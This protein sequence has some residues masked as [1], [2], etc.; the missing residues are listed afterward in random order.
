MTVHCGRAEGVEGIERLVVVVV[1]EGTLLGGERRGGGDRGGA[2]GLPMMKSA[3]CGLGDWNG[4]LARCESVQR[5]DFGGE[6]AE[7]GGLH[8]P[9]MRGLFE[10]RVV[11]LEVVVILT[12]LVEP[13]SLD[14]HPRVRASEAS[15]RE[16]TDHGCS[17]EDVGIVKRDGNLAESAVS[18]AA[19]EH[20]V[21]ALLANQAETF[22]RN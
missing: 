9:L 12:E 15:N 17:D 3:S 21:I 4:K 8:I 6:R 2:F 18:V 11:F 13:G 5:G 22:A 10:M 1:G 14:Q 19:H 20:D 16:Q 7:T